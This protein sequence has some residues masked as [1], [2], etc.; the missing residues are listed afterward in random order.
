MG[1]LACSIGRLL[2]PRLDP[3]EQGSWPL[4]PGDH[5][6]HLRERTITLAAK[7][8]PVLDHRDLMPRTAPFPAGRTPFWNQSSHTV[9]GEAL[10]KDSCNFISLSLF[11]L[12]HFG[13]CRVL[14]SQVSTWR[15]RWRR[16]LPVPSV[17]DTS[18]RG[19]PW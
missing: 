14:L 1:P 2:R 18:S 9:A 3:E 12:W 15:A 5:P 7:H 17:R 4:P 8:H 11:A 13:H 10:S 6:G 16:C 19:S